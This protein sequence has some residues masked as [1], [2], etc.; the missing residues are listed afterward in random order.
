MKQW[1]KPRGVILVLLLFFAISCG[2]NSRVNDHQ[3]LRQNY[4]NVNELLQSE[5]L[6]NPF[7]KIHFV[8]GDVAIMEKWA[9]NEA[10]D[11]VVGEGQLLDFN[12][13]FIKYGSLSLPVESMAL[14]ETNN[15]EEIKARDKE[16]ISKLTAIMAFD[17]LLAAPC[18][19]FP[20]YCFG[21]C[22]T[23]YIEGETDLHE[24]RAEGFSNAI[25]PALENRDIDALKYSTR[26]DVFRIYMKNEAYETHVVNQVELWTVPRKQDEVV[27]VDEDDQFYLTS[28]PVSPL[29]AKV[30]GN[31]ILPSLE[32]MDQE[33]YFSLTDSTDLTTR[34][35]LILEFKP[36]QW[37]DAGLVLNFRQ[38]LL[39]TF[40][41]YEGLSWMGDDVGRYLSKMES[42][43]LLRKKMDQPFRRLGDID[44]YVWDSQKKDWFLAQNVHETGPLA[45]N[46]Q[47][48]PLPANTA[49]S[50]ENLKVKLTM[51][52]GLWRLD[53]AGLAEIKGKVEP[54]KLLPASLTSLARPNN[55]TLDRLTADDEKYLVTFP[56]DEYLLE[57]QMPALKD[58]EEHE[59]FLAAKGYYLEWIRTD[60]LADKNPKKIRKLLMGNKA[61][62]QSLARDYK[63]AE[64]RMEEVFWSSKYANPKN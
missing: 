56:G 20:K 41:L 62:W 32:A 35:D 7:F 9:L 58:N 19:V 28:Q 4:E 54:I 40:L 52:K 21:S 29:T 37:K 13:R 50:G 5:N 30:E 23:F 48:I 36:Q 57:F 33:E 38:T 3:K 11:S 15:Y 55:K 26:E 49:R 47:I 27:F 25:A 59:L 51:A 24:V 61:T 8:N 2:T 34:E 1:T 53:Y 43:K 10:Q 44:C 31:E 18:L 14:I 60:W 17:A 22:P 45:K 6:Q 64:Q 12:R 63:E 42:N 16:I 46:L 39:T